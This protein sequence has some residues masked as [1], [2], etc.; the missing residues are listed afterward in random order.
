MM[1]N[2]KTT[3]KE[4]ISNFEKDKKGMYRYTGKMYA[5]PE[6]WQKKKIQLMGLLG[7]GLILQIIAGCSR[8]GA[9]KNTFY[10]ILPYGGCIGMSLYCLY[11]LYELYAEGDAFKDYIYERHALVM[12]RDLMILYIFC[13]VTAVGAMLYGIRQAENILPE[14]PLMLTEIAAAFCTAFAIRTVK[15]FQWFQKS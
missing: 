1:K 5:A 14:I 13:M 6:N 7:I 8:S 2:R 12:G 11:H 10:V 9:M 15:T 4:Y 3:K